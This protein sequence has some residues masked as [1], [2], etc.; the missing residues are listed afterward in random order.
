[1]ADPPP[2][3]E[4]IPNIPLPQGCWGSAYG[5]AQ[6]AIYI[7]GAAESNDQCIELIEDPQD[8]AEHI[9]IPLDADF[10]EDPQDGAEHFAFF[11]DGAAPQDLIAP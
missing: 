3:P 7:I 4:N 9:A 6:P 8:G 2:K 10:I 5:G 1:M 11:L